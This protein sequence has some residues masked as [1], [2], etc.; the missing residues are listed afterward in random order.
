ML[1]TFP[2]CNFSLEFPEILKSYMLSLTESVWNFQSNALSVTLHYSI[3][4]VYVI[5]L[6]TIIL[7][8]I[9]FELTMHYCII[10]EYN[11]KLYI[12]IL[13]YTDFELTIIIEYNMKLY[14]ILYYT[15]C[16][17]TLHYLVSAEEACELSMICTDVE[18]K[19]V[20]KGLLRDRLSIHR[21]PDHSLSDQVSYNR[22]L[23]GWGAV[24][25]Y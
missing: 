19:L 14:T 16:E 3:I 7:Y 23:Y 15:D 4:I 25:S 22:T 2:Q 6:Y 11:M 20:W 13:Y 10:I 9:D 1:R 5:K 21:D 18:T 17:L 24:H 8:Y 12:I